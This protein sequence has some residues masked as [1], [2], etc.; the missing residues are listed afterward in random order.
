MYPQVLVVNPQVLQSMAP[1]S[2]P[3]EIPVLK[4]LHRQEVRL[5]FVD[6][7]QN[8]VSIKLVHCFEECNM[9]WKTILNMVRTKSLSFQFA[10]LGIVG[11]W[12]P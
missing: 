8:W 6:V 1:S 12:K 3:V 10:K 2:P 9:V 7:N 5:E 11:L 4:N